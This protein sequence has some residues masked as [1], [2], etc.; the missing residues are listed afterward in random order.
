[1]ISCLLT[2]TRR[3]KVRELATTHARVA[4]AEVAESAE[5]PPP[6]SAGAALTA[7]SSAPRSAKAA[8]AACAA[9]VGA[10]EALEQL[11]S[12]KGAGAAAARAATLAASDIS[13]SASGAFTVRA[14]C[15]EM[16]TRGEIDAAVDDDGGSFLVF[17]QPCCHG[18]ESK[19]GDAVG[20][21]STAS[22]ANVAFSRQTSHSSRLPREGPATILEVAAVRRAMATSMHLW[23]ELS[24][25][26]SAVRATAEFART[27]D[28]SHKLKRELVASTRKTKSE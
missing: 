5:M 19:G 23:K 27:L 20:A 13:A 12:C 3:W 8:T 14:L 15:E 1:M 24:Q 21:A 16:I 28:T 9:L 22:A 2:A 18:A 10:A 11:P 25:A 6:R 7:I 26:R 17:H 4:L